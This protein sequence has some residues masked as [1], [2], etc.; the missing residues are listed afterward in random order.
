M[1]IPKNKYIKVTHNF[2]VPPDKYEHAD[3][4]A[5]IFCLPLKAVGIVESKDELVFYNNLFNKNKSIGLYRDCISGCGDCGTDSL[6][7][8]LS[9]I[10]DEEKTILVLSHLYKAHERGISFLDGVSE[11]VFTELEQPMKCHGKTIMSQSL[12]PKASGSDTIELCRLIRNGH[13][14]EVV[15]SN[16]SMAE[17]DF[18]KYLGSFGVVF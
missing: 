10:P 9:N 6:C 14:W 4:D 1:K 2:V 17:P 15:F 18:P 5:D 12:S 3:Y 8:D 7:V 11:V 16:D 13:E